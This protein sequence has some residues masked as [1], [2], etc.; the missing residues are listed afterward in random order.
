M[1][2]LTGFVKPAELD[3]A[4]TTRAAASTALSTATWTSTLATKLG[5][6]IETTVIKSI[7]TGFVNGSTGAATGSGETT[8]YRDVTVT[9]VTTAKCAV[10][11]AGQV[12]ESDGVTYNG[13]PTT[14]YLTSTTN[15]RVCS[16]TSANNFKVRWTVIEF[17]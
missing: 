2:T 13:N 9:S 12:G 3:A 6:T 10:L 14:A 7:Q 17:K 11:V 5:N 15:L 16:P 8:R 4:I 1:S